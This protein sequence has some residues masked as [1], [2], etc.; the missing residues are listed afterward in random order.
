MTLCPPWQILYATTHTNIGQ[1]AFSEV[2][3]SGGVLRAVILF[4]GESQSGCFR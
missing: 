4:L 3:L 1:L 2:A